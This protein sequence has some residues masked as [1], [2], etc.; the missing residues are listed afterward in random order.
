MH[1]EKK[2][3]SGKYIDCIECLNLAKQ[4]N[5]STW[6]SELGLF[7]MSISLARKIIIT[8]KS[9]EFFYESIRWTVKRLRVSKHTSVG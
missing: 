3:A 7:Q 1:I 4:L 5:S 9:Q 6:K 2:K 8:P